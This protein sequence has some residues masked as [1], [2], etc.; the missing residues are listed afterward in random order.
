M[1]KRIAALFGGK[2]SE[3][4]V[5]LS[6]AFAL[7]SEIDS[8]K[9][10]VCKIGITKN[11]KWYLYEGDLDAILHDKWQESGK[12]SK[13]LFSPNNGECEMLVQKDGEL[14]PLKIDAAF[15]MLHGKFGEDGQIQGMFS[16]MGV[17][18]VGCGAASSA[19]C[20]DKVLTKAVVEKLD[21]IRQAKCIILRDGDS[22]SD[23]ASEA[24]VLLGYPMFV[25]PACAGSSVGVSKVK[26]RSEFDAAIE[27]ALAED[28]RVVIEEAIVGI[29]TEVAVLEENGKYT[30]SVP[31]E[32]DSGSSE[33]Y[34]YDT[35]YISD[36]SSFYIPARIPENK[37]AEV[38]D[39][40]ERI[41]RALDCRSLSRVDFFYTP[42]GEF[43]FNEINTIPGCTPISMYPKLMMNEG[44]SFCELT[45]RLIESAHL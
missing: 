7:L 10:D 38:R 1:K 27:K 6:T 21:G 3:Y 42:D 4:E 22:V 43:V 9:Y 12:I 5:S 19:V 44:M 30:V 16:V 35:K 14:T 17:P 20:M 45:T 32:I 40:A 36:V 23:A 8:E 37:I 41:F 26:D 11:G 2:S 25:K 28:S 31:A 34:D 39:S 15:P 18:V 29:E 24:E 33:F 13:I